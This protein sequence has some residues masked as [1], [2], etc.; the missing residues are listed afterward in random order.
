MADICTSIAILEAGNL[1]AHGDID[2]MMRELRAHRLIQVRVL[3]DLAPL[4]DF[5]LR[6]ENAELLPAEATAELPS[7]TLRFDFAGSDEE[8]SDLLNTLI[9]SGIKIISF[10]EDVGDLEDVFLHLTQGIVN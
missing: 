10:H 5:V 2:T 4:Q 3:G 6:T 9:R 7:D 8:L 1:V